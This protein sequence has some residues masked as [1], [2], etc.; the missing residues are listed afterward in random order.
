MKVLL[1]TNVL[2]SS[3]VFDGYLRQLIEILLSG[4]FDVYIPDY[5]DNEFQRIL[6]LKW[7]ND[8]EK[9]YKT[10]HKMSFR[11]VK[12]SEEKLV[13]LRDS[14]DD[15]VLSD[16]IYYDVDVLVTGDKDFFDTNIQKPVIMTPK[17]LFDYLNK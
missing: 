10:F 1:D 9:L 7:Q 4:N 13:K 5:V 11:F 3:F 17:M 6:K 2:I 15:Q 8:W 16:A 12:S 14:K